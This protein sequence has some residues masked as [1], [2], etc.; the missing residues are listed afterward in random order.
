MTKSLESRAARTAVGNV[1]LWING[2]ETAPISAESGN[3][4]N[5]ATGAVIRRVPFANARDI[6]LAVAAAEAAFPAW[7]ATPPLRRARVLAKFAQLLQDHQ[8]D[9]AQI[10]SEEHGKTVADA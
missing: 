2:K 6:D 1:P 10:I 3:V 4:T 7:R 8:D 9:L 5:P